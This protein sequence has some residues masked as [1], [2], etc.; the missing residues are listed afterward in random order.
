VV[1]REVREF[2]DATDIADEFYRALTS[3]SFEIKTEIRFIP[4][5]QGGVR[6][7]VRAKVSPRRDK[8]RDKEPDKD[9][10]KARDKRWG[11]KR[12]SDDDAE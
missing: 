4:N 6:P 11:S 2:L 10:D 7:D 9:R 5:D 12:S 3:L 1:A 8:D